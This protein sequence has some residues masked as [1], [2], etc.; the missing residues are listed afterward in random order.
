M[1]AAQSPAAVRRA[2]KLGIGVLYDSLQTPERI[3]RLSD[4]YRE[5]GGAGAQ[6][7]IRRVWVGPPPSAS[8]ARQMDFYRSYAKDETQRHWGEGQELIAGRDGAELAERLAE[9][10]ESAGCDALNLRVHLL[11][12]RPAAV[13]EQIERIGAETL[14][15]LRERL[16]KRRGA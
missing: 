7:A 14:P 13:R 11:G 5:A 2:A 1:S 9:L 4:A 10:V 3:H 16:A 12:V 6:I 8:E 15:L